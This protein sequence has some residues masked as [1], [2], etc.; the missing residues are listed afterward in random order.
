MGGVLSQKCF[1]SQN[2]IGFA[3]NAESSLTAL[4]NLK[5]R[6][7]RCVDVLRSPSLSYLRENVVSRRRWRFRSLCKRHCTRQKLLL[8]PAPKRT[9]GGAG[10]FLHRVLAEKLLLSA[11]TET[12]LSIPTGLKK[13]WLGKTCTMSRVWLT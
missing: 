12:N 11:N 7:R 5:D 13:P 9:E 3:K 10:M 6:T 8:Y 2:A 4:C 1:Y